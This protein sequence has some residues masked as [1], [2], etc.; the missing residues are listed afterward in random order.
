MRR[1]LC[2]HGRA[3]GRASA[4]RRPECRR[5]RGGASGAVALDTSRGRRPRSQRARR[6]PA[7]GRRGGP[8]GS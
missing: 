5:A 2:P 1:P 7:R 4:R 3:P 6:T 8:G